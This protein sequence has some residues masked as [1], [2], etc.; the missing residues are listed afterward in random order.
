MSQTTDSAYST[1]ALRMR[2]FDGNFHSSYSTDGGDY[3]T[4]IAPAL[5][6][7]ESRD[8]FV[9]LAYVAS[10]EC[11]SAEEIANARAYMIAA[12]DDALSINMS[13]GENEHYEG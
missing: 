2:T 13:E 11:K 6:E 1:L 5:A 12:I 10:C 7:S 3:D 4:I 9:H 8:G